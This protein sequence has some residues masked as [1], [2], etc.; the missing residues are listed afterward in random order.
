M[1]PIYFLLYHKKPW[2]REEN[3]LKIRQSVHNVRLLIL[4]WFYEIMQG[5][6][7]FHWGKY[8]LLNPETILETMSMLDWPILPAKKQI[9]ILEASWWVQF[10]I[11]TLT[12]M[13]VPYKL[14]V[15]YEL[16]VAFL[17]IVKDVSPSE[18][19]R[20]IG[21]KRSF[22][23]L[24]WPRLNSRRALPPIKQKLSI[25]VLIVSIQS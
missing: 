18:F 2:N 8:F 3:A 14:Y 21:R 13:L 12:H 4:I 19:S 5:W 22:S 17:Y 11:K 24:N 9:S 10:Y 23:L 25:C 7:G 20:N 1:L 15:T 16:G 6:S